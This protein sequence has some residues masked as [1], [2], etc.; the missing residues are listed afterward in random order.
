MSKQHKERLSISSLSFLLKIVFF[1]IFTMSF[2][3][4]SRTSFLFFIDAVVLLLISEVDRQTEEVRKRK[5]NTSQ[6]EQQTN[7]QQKPFH[8]TAFHISMRFSLIEFR[9]RSKN[10][11]VMGRKCRWIRTLWG[12]VKT[13]PFNDQNSIRVM[14]ESLG[15]IVSPVGVREDVWSRGNRDGKKNK[16]DNKTIKSR[17]QTEQ[18]KTK[19]E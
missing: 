14:V 9:E 19:T 5:K 16:N 8:T 18:N 10:F 7:K 1:L 13:D 6:N 17:K 2:S 11:V 3:T 15:D 4:P 12:I